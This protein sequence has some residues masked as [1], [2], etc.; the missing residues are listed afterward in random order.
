MGPITARTIRN[1]DA[2]QLRIAIEGSAGINCDFASTAISFGPH[3]VFALATLHRILL[4]D[5]HELGA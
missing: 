2:W 5:L 4:P 1:D 3:E